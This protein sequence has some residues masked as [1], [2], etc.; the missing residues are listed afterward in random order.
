[1]KKEDRHK[2]EGAFT[3][4]VKNLKWFY[5]LVRGLGRWKLF[6]K[7]TKIFLLDLVQIQS[8]PGTAEKKNTLVSICDGDFINKASNTKQHIPI[9]RSL[10]LHV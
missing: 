3:I 5:L 7:C 1:M 10:F 4:A 9:L 6:Q 2:A 8:H